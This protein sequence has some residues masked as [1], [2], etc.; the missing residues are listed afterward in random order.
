MYSRDGARIASGWALTTQSAAQWADVNLSNRGLDSF[1]QRY[2]ST[3]VDWVVG[4]LFVFAFN[5]RLI[6]LSLDYLVMYVGGVVDVGIES[7]EA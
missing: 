5:V 1:F 7:F 2:S 3:V 6:S 4:W